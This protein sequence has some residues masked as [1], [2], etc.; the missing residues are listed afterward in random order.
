MLVNESQAG[1]S[2]TV[3]AILL[4]EYCKGKPPKTNDQ[5]VLAEQNV[6]LLIAACRREHSREEG[7][8]QPIQLGGA[9]IARF[10]VEK[11]ITFSRDT[12]SD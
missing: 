2:A 12:E 9:R 4:A 7:W 10:I 11:A 8:R 3:R 1:D 6:D 5:R